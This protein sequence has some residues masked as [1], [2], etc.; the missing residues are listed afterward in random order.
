MTPLLGADCHAHVFNPTRFKYQ[1]DEIYTPLACQEG[2]PDQFLTLLELHQLSHGL[3]VGAGPYGHDNSCLL[4]AIAQSN[5]RFKGIALVPN[6]VTE[7]EVERLAAGGIVG[8]RINLFNHGVSVLEDAEMPNLLAKIKAANWF[9]QIQYGK[10]QLVDALPI[11]ERAGVRVIIDHCGRPDLSRGIQ[12]PGFQAL[13]ALGR[14]SNA[15]VKLSAVYRFSQQPYPY[16]DVEPYIQALVEA[17][18]I[19][20]CVWA[21]DWPFTR[22]DARMDYSPLLACLKRWFPDD[23]DRQRILC[24]NPARLFGFGQ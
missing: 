20:R 15:V 21:S 4:D 1:T 2:T 22:F 10:D 11:L 13:L 23:N 16:S 18:T 6:N 5:Q 19:E 12:Q 9:A 17:F 7:H 14:N 3:L 24:A 8:V